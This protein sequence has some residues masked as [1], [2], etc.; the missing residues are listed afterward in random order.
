MVAGLQHDA[1]HV[2]MKLLELERA[3]SNIDSHRCRVLS[4]VLKNH[5][6]RNILKTRNGHC[7]GA[8]D[9]AHEASLCV[10]HDSLD[11]LGS[12]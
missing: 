12:S 11:S 4:L 1:S 7:V 3:V 2:K 5:G 10:R 8:Q 6:L 9:D